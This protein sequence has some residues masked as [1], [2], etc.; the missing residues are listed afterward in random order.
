MLER[1]E[2]TVWSLVRIVGGLVALTA[3]A[4]GVFAIALGIHAILKVW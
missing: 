1:I 4:W 2:S 3:A